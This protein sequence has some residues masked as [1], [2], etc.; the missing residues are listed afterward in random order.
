MNTEQETKTSSDAIRDFTVH[1]TAQVPLQV[2]H[3]HYEHGGLSVPFHWHKEMEWIWVEKGNLSLTLESETRTISEG[4]FLCINSHELHQ[5][6]SIGDTPSVHHALVFLPEIL[7]C[8]YLDS[9]ETDWISPLL[10]REL[11]LPAFPLESLANAFHEPKQF[12]TQLCRLFLEILSAYDTQFPGWFL[13]VKSGLY[14]ILALFAQNHLFVP[15]NNISSQRKEK[16]SQCKEILRYIQNHYD[17]KIQLA[18]LSAV[19]DMNPQYFCR[20]FKAQFQMTPISYINYY[21]AAQ[22]AKLLSSSSLSVLEISLHSGFENPSYFASIFRRYFGVSPEQYRKA[23]KQ[24]L[25][26]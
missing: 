11:F 16:A 10:S 18:E 26:L 20:F 12:S 1:G 3:Q 21:R 8:S 9:C 6:R 25:F 13:Q 22:A 4:T 23:K 24:E 14:Q 19:L 5:L 7:S 2:Y 17:R 15:Q